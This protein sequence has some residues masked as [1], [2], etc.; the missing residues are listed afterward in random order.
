MPSFDEELNEINDQRNYFRLYS[1]HT[2]A[3]NTTKIIDYDCNANK[4][5][6]KS[7]SKAQK[8]CRLYAKLK[9]KTTFVQLKKNSNKQPIFLLMKKFSTHSTK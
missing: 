9:Q 7:D 3:L 1:I 4:G 5:W 2:N 6:F 8:Y